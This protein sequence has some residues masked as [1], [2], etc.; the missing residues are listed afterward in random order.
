[1]DFLSLDPVLG[2][3]FD[4]EDIVG[5]FRIDL[6]GAMMPLIGIDMYDVKV[7]TKEIVSSALTLSDHSTAMGRPKLDSELYDMTAERSNWQRVAHVSVGLVPKGVPVIPIYHCD[8][9]QSIPIGTVIAPF[10]DYQLVWDEVTMLSQK[11]LMH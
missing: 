7:S 10:N 6:G 8:E 11:G 5:F 3:A 2:P 1:M 9:L 4:A